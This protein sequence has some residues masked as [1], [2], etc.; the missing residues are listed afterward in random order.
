MPV[1][2]QFLPIKQTG[3]TEI[4]QALRLWCFSVANQTAPVSRY[5]ALCLWCFN[6]YQSNRYCPS[7]LFSF[8]DLFLPTRR[9]SKLKLHGHKAYNISF[10]STLLL[11]KLGTT[12]IKPCDTISAFILYKITSF[13]N[14]PAHE[15]PLEMQLAI[16]VGDGLVIIAHLL[17]T[18]P[19]AKCSQSRRS[20]IFNNPFTSSRFSSRAALE[21]QQGQ[22]PTSRRIETRRGVSFISQSVHPP[23]FF[24]FVLLVI[25]TKIQANPAMI[26]CQPG[27]WLFNP[28]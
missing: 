3:S 17:V 26:D 10:I 15:T 22:R 7:E 1:V 6:F 12:G 27:C 5:Q 14:L 9:R 21:R 4:P 13:L 25:G 8:N 18:D 16:T 19:Q 23:L 24:V 2:L 20:H 11:V 28:S